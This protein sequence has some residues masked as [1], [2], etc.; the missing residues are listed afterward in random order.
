MIRPSGP[1]G[2]V[3]ADKFRREKIGPVAACSVALRNSREVELGILEECTL[4][5]KAFAERIL[6][7]L[8]HQHAEKIGTHPRMQVLA[9][10]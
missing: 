7:I 6:Q 9:D 3:A 8:G 1:V 2:E 10:L 5:L 4:D